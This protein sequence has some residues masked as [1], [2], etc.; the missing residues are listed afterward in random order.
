MNTRHEN[1]YQIL[2]HRFNCLMVSTAKANH[3]AGKE[4][5]SRVTYEESEQGFARRELLN[6]EKQAIEDR[7]RREIDEGS[8][9][10]S[11][12]NQFHRTLLV[13]FESQIS[14]VPFLFNEVLGLNDALG[15]LLDML[16][17]KACT[18]SRLEPLAARVPWLYDELL[19]VVNAPQHRRKDSRGKVI[20]VESL[21][22]ALSFINID[23]LK[24]LL[25]T[26]AFRRTIP[27]VTDPYPNI[28]LRAHQYAVMTGLTARELA[29]R[30]GVRPNDAFV[31][32]VFT[33]LGR[34]AVTR[35][36]FKLF[37][38]VKRSEL[39]RAQQEQKR[40]LH[41]A[42]TKITPSSNFLIAL[43]ND[44]SA[45]ITAQTIQHMQL[46]RVFINDAAS[47][48]ASQESLEELPLANL[49]SQA[50]CYAQF[51]MLSSHKLLSTE[52][53]HAEAKT[54]LRKSQLNPMDI[55]RLKHLD[56]ASLPLIINP[57]LDNA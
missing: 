26:L 36:Y 30:A 47:A 7:K 17:T 56:L 29:K 23:N 41:D 55:E 38:K 2:L 1:Q 35:L 52:K 5:I 32:G 34:N 24:L 8:Y 14:D 53:E 42:L 18:V 43:W 21:R 33:G 20:V 22:T 25:P 4:S 10:D 9:V 44:F 54:L 39:E 37:E 19:K 31:L 3:F 50:S 6:V 16:A 46:R 28:K 40:E 12:R 13:H 51:R 11:V 45:S 48:L 27:Q 57:E 49:V 15:E